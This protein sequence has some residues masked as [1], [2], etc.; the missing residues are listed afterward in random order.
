M[1]FKPLA[2]LLPSVAGGGTTLTTGLQAVWS[3]N[4]ASAPITDELGNYNSTGVGGTLSYGET[5]ILGDCILGDGGSSS[6]AEFGDI[7][8]MGL[9]DVSLSVWF[10]SIDSIGGI[11][12]QSSAGNNGCYFIELSSGNVRAF[13]R[14]NG[15]TYLITGSSANDGDWHLGI[16]TFDRDGFMRLYLD[17][18][19]VGT[20]LDISSQSAYDA[21]GSGYFDMFAR[22]ATTTLANFLNGYI[23]QSAVWY[24]V[25]SSEER[26][27]LWN[28]GNGLSFDNW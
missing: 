12:G 6:Y 26:G 11:T 28:S 5:G 15:S 27:L 21:P 25:L 10:K 3:M 2:G 24:K 7:L 19:E 23:D 9:S 17:N 20:A 13:S 16:V 1:I 8:P 14:L 18:S 22:R 4:D